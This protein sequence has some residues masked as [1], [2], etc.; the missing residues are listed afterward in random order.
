MIRGIEMGQQRAVRVSPPGAHEDSFDGWLVLEVFSEGRLHGQVVACEVKMVSR[1]ALVDEAVDL[2][3]RV[4]RY[5][6]DGLE[7]RGQR[8]GP[9]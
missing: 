6:V 2:C 3:E 9:R 7:S 8:E 4:G 1:D 5:D